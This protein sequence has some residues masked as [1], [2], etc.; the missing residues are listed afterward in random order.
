MLILLVRN[1]GREGKT[2]VG[3]MDFVRLKKGGVWGPDCFWFCY[4]FS[5]HYEG[6]QE[7]IRHH[8]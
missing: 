6:N 7:L 1:V 2:A 8:L 5:G 4:L 3:C